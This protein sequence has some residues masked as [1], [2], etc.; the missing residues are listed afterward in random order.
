ME[1]LSFQ[2]FDDV[3]ALTT[4]IFAY[5]NQNGKMQPVGKLLF[6]REDK[7]IFTPDQT[8]RREF[9]IAEINTFPRHRR[10]GVATALMQEFFRMMEEIEIPVIVELEVCPTAETEEDF[11]KKQ[12]YLLKFYEKMGFKIN[13]EPTMCNNVP[14][15]FKTFNNA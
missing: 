8:K 11:F 2:M 1:K 5:Q 7:E 14:V 15:M 4:T 3:G 12:K 9:Y 6:V 10:Q 13:P